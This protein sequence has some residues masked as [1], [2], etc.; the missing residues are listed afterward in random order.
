M[1]KSIQ[2]KLVIV[3]VLLVVSVII[4]IGT[5]LLYSITDFYH[6][7]FINEMDNV[8]AN[9]SQDFLP[10]ERTSENLSNKLKVF[11]VQLGLDSYRHYYILNALGGVLDSS[12][13]L[14]SNI[15]ST[16]NI[17]SA[18][19]GKIGKEYKTSDAYMD[20]AYPVF[21]ENS[22]DKV[23]YIIYVQDT[24]E[25]LRLLLSTQINKNIFY[26]L[27]LGL[28]ISFI[29]GFLLSNTITT[30]IALLT[31]KAE[32]L[33]AG[34]FEQ[35]M[36]VVS[37]DEIGKLAG[38]FNFMAAELQENMHEIS[39]ERNK[40]EAI[41]FHMTD[42]LLAFNL[43]GE[44]THM[45]LAAKKMLGID[46][47]DIG[48]FDDYFRKINIFITLEDL[49]CLDSHEA[50]ERQIDINNFHIKAYFVPFRLEKDRL[51]GVIV[52]LQDITEQQKLELVRREFVANVS[53][54]LKT[55]LT[56]IK[57]YAETLLDGAVDDRDTAIHF[58]RVINS[59]SDRMTRLVRDLLVL[60]HLDYKQ[61]EWKKGHFSLIKL[62]EEVMEKLS[63]QAKS[64]DHKI[65]L[66]RVTDVPD[67]FGDQ[68]KI[69]QVL[70][71]IVSNAIKYTPDGGEISI[72][73]GCIQKEAYV[74]IKD[75][76]IGIPKEDLSRIFER[77]YRVD[78]AR[79]RELGGTGLGLSIAKEI[80]T[81]HGGS[82]SIDSEPAQG[83]EVT[84]KLPVDKAE[85]M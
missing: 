5:F 72:T 73:A 24:K 66:T 8:F 58:L 50:V 42:G 37:K 31:K 55:P 83:T 49:I 7:Q 85:V 63:L 53:H 3:F 16:P 2:W 11:S 26:A 75:N 54:E 40:M 29:L 79:S 82:I 69:E 64:H 38:A 48:C 67:V 20:Y 28:I 41:L 68:D 6:K 34:D 65:I 22:Q 78:K 32:K 71:N 80:I 30:P 9:E 59:E 12:N 51:G 10:L 77:F 70:L 46:K 25:E 23:K 35:V 56:S 19:N 47:Q 33:A 39:S 44:I 18:I 17:I 52:V 81:A 74:K 45:N 21:W 84:I 43:D 1:T 36:E 62:V 4:V 57:S 60:S 61:T 14:E 76:G 27:F 15:E 13:S